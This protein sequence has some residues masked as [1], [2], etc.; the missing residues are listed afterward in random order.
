VSV[1]SDIIRVTSWVAA[2]GFHDYSA[3]IIEYHIL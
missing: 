2:S 1:S 3:N